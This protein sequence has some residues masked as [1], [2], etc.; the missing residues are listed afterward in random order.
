MATPQAGL[1]RLRQ[2]NLRYAA[3]DSVRHVPI[4]NQRPFAVVVGCADSRVGPEIVFGQENGDLFVIRVAGGV[5]SASVIGS[6]EYAIAELGAALVVVLGHSHCGAVQATITSCHSGRAAQS[7]S[8]EAIVGAIR[9]VIKPILA[10]ATD[11]HD[12]MDLAVTANTHA[13]AQALLESSD[14]IGKAVRN[15]SVVVTGAVFDLESGRV[16]FLSP[17][18]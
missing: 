12:L 8:L 14:I 5:P 17:L 13:T 1:E 10:T 11:D 16:R 15:D 18:T 3:G 9:P 4:P 7:P 2:G 6:V